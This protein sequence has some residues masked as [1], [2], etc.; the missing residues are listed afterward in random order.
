M[1]FTTACSESGEGSTSM[2]HIRSHVA[3]KSSFY[4]LGSESNN[5]KAFFFCLLAALKRYFVS[6]Y[7]LAKQKTDRK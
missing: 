1:G 2:L 7:E 4:C 6:Q 3:Q 5:Y